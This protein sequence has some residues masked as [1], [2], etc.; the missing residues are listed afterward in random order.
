MTSND[1]GYQDHDT[2][3]DQDQSEHEHD[4]S[5][6]EHDHTEHD[7]S[8]PEH[9]DEPADL[10][11][12]DLSQT[13]LEHDDTVVADDVTLADPAAPSALDGQPVIAIVETDDLDDD[14]SDSLESGPDPVLADDSISA[15]DPVAVDD[16]DDIV[17]APEPTPAPLTVVPDPVSETVLEPA[18]PATPASA[19]SDWLGLQGRFVDDPAA[20]VQEAGNRV[21]QALADLRAQLETGSTEDLRTAFRRYRDLHA[22]LR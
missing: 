10:E 15:D 9:T 19:D 17:L 5:E 13:D 16:A 14:A 8:D 21:E 1:A 20:A 6:H 4:H 11:P 7:H 22:S 2:V 3:T 18:A 12:V